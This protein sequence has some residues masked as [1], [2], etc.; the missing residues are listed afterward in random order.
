MSVL[1]LGVE[2]TEIS[3]NGLVMW[4]VNL[5]LLVGMGIIA[6]SLKRLISQNDREH[7]DLKRFQEKQ[8]DDLDLRIEKLL[9]LIAAEREARHTFHGELETRAWHINADLKENYSPSRETGRMYGSMRQA[10]DQHH[11][12]TMA[13]IDALPC[14]GPVC[15]GTSPGENSQ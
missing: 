8:H 2:L 5:V 9:D 7:G 1:P 4:L 12:E 14:H 3:V 11:A 15:P 10:I 13:R 6:W